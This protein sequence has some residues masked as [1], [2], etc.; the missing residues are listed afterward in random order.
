M[1]T[2]NSECP[3]KRSAVHLSSPQDLNF[4]SGYDDPVAPLLAILESSFDGIYLTDGDANT[5]WCNRSY[6]VISG[7]NRDEVIGH[8]MRD[9]V[10]DGIIS[11]S[12]TLLTLAKR[13]AITLDQ[14]FKTGRQTVITST[15]I[16]GDND[17]IIMVVTNVR[18]MSEV[19]SLKSELARN[20]KMAERYQAEVELIR[21]QLMNNTG[22]VAVDRRMLDILRVAQRVA[23]MDTVVLLLGETG[24]GKERIAN[25]IHNSSPRQS[26][27]FIKINCGAIAENLAESELFGYERGAF[28]GAK[29]EG[30]PGLFE[31]ADKGT[32]FLDEVGDLPL[33]IQTKLLRVLQEQE[34]VRVGGSEPIKVDVRILAATNRDLQQLVHTGKF[35]ADLYYRLSVFPITIPPLRERKMDIPN[36]AGSMLAAL[37]KKY[38]KAKS[39]TQAAQDTL[40][41]YDWPGNV[42][43]L[44][45]VMERAF[46]MSEGDLI[47]PEGLSVFNTRVQPE[48]TD[49]GFDLKAHMEQM[50]YSYIKKAFETHSTVRSAARSLGMDPATYLRK[51]KKY[52]MSFSV[53]E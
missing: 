1:L 27:S 10:K 42:R 40:Q 2:K 4:L 25:Y 17:Q 45:N 34:L 38:D 3:R 16:Y 39:L 32:I 35:R 52:E 33:P 14:K 50:E 11:K 41:D 47:S 23:Q 37:N 13:D 7:L 20:Q 6:E 5:I 46:I 19:N 24:V 31:V 48:N 51:K 44:K 28:T 8:N 53:Q 15:P 9:L 30:K 26:R 36:L 21:R 18:D 43:E 12:G 22:L 49:Q 29:K